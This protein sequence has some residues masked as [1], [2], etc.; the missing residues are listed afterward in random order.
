M[1]IDLSPNVAYLPMNPSVRRNPTTGIRSALPLAVQPT[2]L[3]CTR[4][5]I[6]RP[7]GC[8]GGTSADCGAFRDAIGGWRGRRAVLGLSGDPIFGHPHRSST[9]SDGV[10]GRAVQRNSVRAKGHAN[11]QTDNL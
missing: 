11:H 9:D 6:P 1:A 10:F 2:R 3:S 8:W 7:S 5:G 4:G